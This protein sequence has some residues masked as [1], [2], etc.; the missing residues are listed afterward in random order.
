MIKM[1]DTY[2]P[3]EERI[4]WVHGFRGFRPWLFGSMQMS[5]ESVVALSG[6]VWHRASAHI[7]AEREM[8]CF[9]LIFYLML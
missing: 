3:I 6:S 2:N 8:L 1:S 4:I 7:I 5:R 9:N